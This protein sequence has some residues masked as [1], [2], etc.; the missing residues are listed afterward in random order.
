[1]LKRGLLLGAEAVGWGFLFQE[2]KYFLHISN[3]TN[4]RQGNPT[5][6][7]SNP[8]QNMGEQLTGG[9]ILS[10]ANKSLISYISGFIE[11]CKC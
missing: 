7:P 6:L 4:G 5:F 2:S 10:H 1:M 8:H 3:D 11:S 9:G